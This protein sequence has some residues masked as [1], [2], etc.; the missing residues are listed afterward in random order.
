MGGVSFEPALGRPGNT[1]KASLELELI[2]GTL[3][4]GVLESA[5][6]QGETCVRRDLRA[7]HRQRQER[8]P[9]TDGRRHR[10]L[11]LDLNHPRNAHRR[12]AREDELKGARPALEAAGVEFTNGDP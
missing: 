4:R 6:C 1:L 7:S 3:L 9:E 12:A 5:P 11:I 10:P 2:T 8:D